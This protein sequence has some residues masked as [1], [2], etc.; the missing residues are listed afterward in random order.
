[1]R[2]LHRFMA[3][4]KHACRPLPNVV[5]FYLGSTYLGTPPRFVQPRMNESMN[6]TIKTK[7]PT[8][9]CTYHRCTYLFIHLSTLYINRIKRLDS[10]RNAKAYRL[11]S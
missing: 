4:Y 10:I 8:C 9:L 6:E 2:S 1:M 7:I 11:G 3:F 5:F